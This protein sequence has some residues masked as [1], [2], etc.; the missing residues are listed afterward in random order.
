LENGNWTLNTLPF[1]TDLSKVSGRVEVDLSPI[2]EPAR[3][4]E[5][6]VTRGE[7][8]DITALRRIW[9]TDSVGGNKQPITIFDEKAGDGDGGKLAAGNWTVS[10]K[11][12]SDAKSKA[13]TLYFEKF[14]A[15]SIVH[16]IR[17][18]RDTL[19]TNGCV[20]SA[21]QGTALRISLLAAKLIR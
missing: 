17:N 10:F 8:D 3:T 20:S 16:V 9:I 14:D 19:D 7:V 2:G 11:D 6:I 5:A 4:Y 15:K 12:H 13:D 18:D 21:N 1:G